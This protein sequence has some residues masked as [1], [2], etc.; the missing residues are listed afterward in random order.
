MGL[1]STPDIPR[2]MSQSSSRLEQ[3]KRSTPV[4]LNAYDP[5]PSTTKEIPVLSPRKA[6]PLSNQIQPKSSENP[7][8]IQPSPGLTHSRAKCIYFY[9]PAHS[10]L[11]GYGTSSLG[12]VPKQISDRDIY[13]KQSKRY[14]IISIKPV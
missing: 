9:N 12:P 1:F 14:N 6:E 5:Q 4:N 10:R 11:Q 7:Y 2:K 3:M 13:E 8:D